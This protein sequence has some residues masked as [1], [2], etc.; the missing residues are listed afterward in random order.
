MP[1]VPTFFSIACLIHF[2]H[3]NRHLCSLTHG[4]DARAFIRPGGKWDGAKTT[5]DRTWCWWIWCV[6]CFF[7]F[8][9]ISVPLHIV[10]RI[11]SIE[12]L[13]YVFSSERERERPRKVSIS[14]NH[15][16]IFFAVVSGLWPIGATPRSEKF[17]R[18]SSWEM[19]RPWWSLRRECRRH[20]T[21]ASFKRSL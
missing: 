5:V 2:I 15:K 10:V 13:L 1:I 19:I 3:K 6:V 21:V 18:N 4:S 20:V 17:Q 8:F 9:G 16:V 12:I 14:D 11:N 7:G